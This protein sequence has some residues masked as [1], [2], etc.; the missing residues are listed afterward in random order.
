MPDVSGLIEKT[1]H[2][3]PR[4]AGGY[5]SKVGIG[6]GVHCQLARAVLEMCTHQMRITGSQVN[7]NLEETMNKDQF[8][9]FL[10]G[11]R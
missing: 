10:R 9:D 1:L 2:H 5:K 7:F 8:D 11:I 6:K 3:P 4:F